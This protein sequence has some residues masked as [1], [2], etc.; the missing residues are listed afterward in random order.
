[1]QVK[2]VS[3][4][5]RLVEFDS[6]QP[7]PRVCIVGGIHGDELCGVNAISVLED[8]FTTNH[9]LLCGRLLMLVANLE[10]IRLKKRFVDFDLNRAFNSTVAFGY[11]AQLAQRI[12]PHLTGVDYLLDL[13]STSAPTRPFCAGSL[14]KAHLEMFWMLGFETYTCD[15]EVHRGQ[16][17][18]IDEINRLGGVGIAAECGRTG[19]RQIDEVAYKA[20]IRLLQKLGMIPPTEQRP[21]KSRSIIR[22]K[23]IVTA[24][25]EHF[26]F[27]RDFE[28][29]DLVESGEVVAYD[30]GQPVVFSDPFLI[31][32]PTK[33]KLQPGDEA[34]GVGIIEKI[35]F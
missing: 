11:E 34:F 21:P 22:I 9:E 10:A 3:E 13:H 27:T 33:V 14:T 28:N 6:G 5:F 4:G 23:Q 2:I 32:T 18:L 8:E 26:I 7:G 20:F 1:M 12:T 25:T 31:T 35:D 24:K 15:L 29:L 17:M 30:N 19:E 16:V